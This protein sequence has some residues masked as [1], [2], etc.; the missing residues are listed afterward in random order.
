MTGMNSTIYPID[1]LRDPRWSLLTDRHPRASIFHTPGWLELLVKTYG[2]RAVV[3][4]SDLPGAP[5]SNGTVCCVVRSWL[6]GHRLVSLPFS[7]HCEPLV[8]GPE[9]LNSL[10]SLLTQQQGNCG[11]RYVELRP[12]S[13]F[14]REQSGFKPERTFYFHSLDLRGSL[15]SLFRNFHKDCVQRKIHRAEREA[16]TYEAGRSE[17][18]LEKFYHL[19]LLTRRRHQLPPQP[20]IWFRNLITCLGDRL[21]IRVASKDGQPIAGILTLQHKGTLVYK[22]GCSDARFHKMGGMAMLFWK[23]IQEAKRAG[24]DEFDLGRSDCDNPGLVAFKDHWGTT[25]SMLTYL[26]YPA[27]RSGSERERERMHLAKRVFSHVPDGVL[28]MTGRLLYRHMG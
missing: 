13:S 14:D 1:P 26:R 12:R 9:E 21:K 16:L 7:D 15:E 24:L 28:A 17:L 20:L 18:T 11:W 4:T 3:F 2:Y 10:L 22:Y 27:Q 6:T 5:M 25:R 19:M 8:N 23:A